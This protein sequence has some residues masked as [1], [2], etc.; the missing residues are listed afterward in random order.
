MQKVRRKQAKKERDYAAFE[1]E[2]MKK[3]DPNWKHKKGSTSEGVEALAASGKFTAEEIKRMAWT[4]FDEN[5]QA[6]RN[7]EKEEKKD[8][9]TA[10]QKRM[11]SPDKGI[12]SPAFKEFMR[13]RGM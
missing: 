7:P 6:M 3:D 10:K 1:R 2:K 5:Y 13:S 11:D 8:T 9:R 12:N 4:E